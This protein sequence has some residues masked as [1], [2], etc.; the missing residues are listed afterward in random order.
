MA[1]SHLAPTLRRAVDADAPA[2]TELV[3]SAYRHYEPLIGRT[4][5]PMQS[6]SELKPAAHYIVQT[7]QAD[8]TSISVNHRQDRDLR[9]AIL[10]QLQCIVG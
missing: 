2:I 1:E 5:L 3:A 4:P 8:A 6:R 7:Q 9:R 10:H